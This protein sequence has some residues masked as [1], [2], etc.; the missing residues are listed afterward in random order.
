[1]KAP[2]YPSIE[3]SLLEPDETAHV[4]VSVTLIQGR[5]ITGRMRHFSPANSTFDV[6]VEQTDESTGMPYILNLN[7]ETK[8]VIYLGF[9]KKEGQASILPPPGSRPIKIYTVGGKVFWVKTR[10]SLMK[11]PVGFYAFPLEPQKSLF[12]HMYFYAHSIRQQESAEY[13]GSMLTR[14]KHVTSDQ[15]NQGLNLQAQRHATKIGEILV[16]QDKVSREDIDAAVQSQNDRP[17]RL[18]L[19]EVLIEAGLI[20]E[21]ELREALQAQQKSKGARIGDLL[22]ELGHISEDTL[23]FTL[24]EKFYLP[25]VNLND[26]AIDWKAFREVELGWLETHSFLPLRSTNRTIT[27]AISDPLNWTLVDLLRFR[28]GKEVQEVMVR[29]SQLEKF[30]AKAKQLYEGETVTIEK[31]LA[32]QEVNTI[33]EDIEITRKA[34]EAEKAGGEKGEEIVVNNT[35]VV[36][37][38]DPPIARLANQVILDAY[39]N[40]TSDIHIEP[41]GEE[42]PCRIR[43]R[44]D[45]KCELYKEVP[46]NLWRKLVTRYKVMSQLDIAERRIPQDGK[47]RMQLEDRILELRVATVPTTNQNEDVVMRL[48]AASEPLP[49]DKMGF[50]TRNDDELRRII[51]IPYG[52]ILCVGPTGS[53]K[54][55]TLHSLLGFINRV[56]RKIWT[57]EDPVEITQ[58]GLRQVQVNPRTGM[59]FAKAM[60]AFL[61]ADPD[62]IMVGEMRDLETAETGV[63][64]SLTGHLVLSTLHTNSAPETVTRLLDLGLDPFSFADSLLGVLA[65]RLARRLCSSCK[66]AYHP[67][68]HEYDHLL[69]SYGHEHWEAHGLPSYDD[70]ELYRA[71]GCGKCRGSGYKGRLGLHELLIGDNEEIRSSIQHK[72]PVA[73]IR[74]LSIEHGMTTL[75]QDGIAKTLQGITDIKQVLAVCS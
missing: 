61:R 23:Y 12:S 27:I 9:A 29:P 60:R 49:L 6:D 46:A 71:P 25:Y 54:T 21:I 18:R 11:D 73:E 24:A 63:E 15:L 16:E 40:N 65:Q 2:S 30:I 33:L 38:D 57:A 14:D 72:A 17:R 35:I 31:V 68:R 5:E 32:T 51:E 42:G 58:R 10:L 70:L 44:I 22:I 53:G 26:Y 19:G 13:L 64:A 48:L 62:V 41:Q 75:M 28:T 47:I 3:L 4:S 45:G 50:S 67:E 52:L 43:F 7:I 59:T 37:D 8:D 66:E 34:E 69:E 1:M 55:T 39:E 56:D 36:S 74:D 20:D